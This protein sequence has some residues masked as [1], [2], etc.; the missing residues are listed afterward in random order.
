MRQHSP[1]FLAALLFLSISACGHPKLPRTPLFPYGHQGEVKSQAS[2]PA[3]IYIDTDTTVV[4]RV[5]GLGVQWDPSDIWDYTPSQW[6]LTFERVDRLAPPFIRCMFGAESYCRLDN[7]GSPYYDWAAPGMQ[8]LYPILEYCQRHH[9]QVMLGEWGPPFGWKSDDPRWSKIIG[10][11]LD[12][13]IN[14][15]DFNCIRYY[16]KIN[17]PQ[18]GSES[19][20][21]WLSAQTSL[22]AEI[23]R[24]H[25]EKKVMMVGPDASGR[26]AVQ[27]WLQYMLS[28]AP[29]L[30]GAYE[31]H[32]YASSTTD[33]PNGEVEHGLGLARA[34]ISAMQPQ[35]PLFIGEAGTG[36]WLNGD[37]NRYI[38]DFS[39]GVFMADYAV[40]AFRA[41][42]TGLSAWMLDDSM[43]QQPGSIPYGSKPSGD[44]KVDF[45]FKAWGFWNGEGKAMGKPQDEKLRP[46]F[47]TWSLLSH[48]FPRGSRIVKV[49]DPHVTGVR[50]TAVVLEDRDLSL[51]VVNDSQVPQKVTLKLLNALGPANLAEYRYFETDRP[52]DAL[53]YPV[54]KQMRRDVNIRSGLEIS[55]PS[56]GVVLFT[57]L[58]GGIPPKL[59]KGALLPVS[60]V[61]LT[62]ICGL[63]DMEVG[64]TIKLSAVTEPGVSPVTWYVSNPSVATVNKEGVLVGLSEGRVKV[65]A[66]SE[67]GPSASVEIEVRSAGLVVD[68]M[69]NWART[70]A[71]DGSLWFES[72]HTN[73]FEGDTSRLKRGADEPSSITWHYPAIRDFSAKLYF[74]GSVADKVR[75]YTSPDGKAWTPL[76]LNHEAPVPT[77]DGWFRALFEAEAIPPGINFVKLEMR[78]DPI[79]WSPQLGEVRLHHGR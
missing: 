51:V 59:G 13:L 30:V 52:T 31:G 25:L 26:D 3:E 1:M 66:K 68:T 9:V 70:S 35:K 60:D 73:L 69:A 55:L 16:N 78:N 28:D 44:P 65:V 77:A 27:D 39:Y 42:L 19:F 5:M 67:A 53:G 37:S 48:C 15:C 41:G 47:Y 57:S 79:S 23:E 24:L 40:Q 29:N 34:T 46:W 64:E 43:H 21:T 32:W 10:R 45:D 75:A 58:D 36:E 38:R 74:F 54:I 6:K 7:S 71:H 56:Q 61:Q 62:T 8:R 50:A 33:I 14:D 76:K 17:E 72:I 4:P 49:S 18:G 11:C 22:K 63:R 2:N 20:R 12:H